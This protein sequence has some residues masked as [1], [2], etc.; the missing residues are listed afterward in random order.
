EAMPL[1]AV[2]D[3]EAE[4]LWSG[5]SGSSVAWSP[6]GERIA[7][8][9]AYPEPLIQVVDAAS[10]EVLWETEGTQPDW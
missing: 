1:W 8:D 2:I 5:A 10:G 4:E 9:V 3:R 6:D 7:V